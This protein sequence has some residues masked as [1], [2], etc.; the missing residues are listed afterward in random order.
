M[1]DDPSEI[2][3]ALSR[4][5]HAIDQRDPRS[6]ED[7]F[8]EDA[9]VIYSGFDAGQSRQSILEYLR[10]AGGFDGE[11]WGASTHA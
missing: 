11:K 2:L 8:A 7:S 1:G 4:H 10:R 5:L 3:T 9:Q 6:V